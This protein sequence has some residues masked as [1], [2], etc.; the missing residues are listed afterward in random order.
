[1]ELAEE[2]WMK[3]PEMAVTRMEK[4]LKTALVKDAALRSLRET[5][6]ELSGAIDELEAS[7]SQAEKD[8]QIGTARITELG[9]YF[10]YLSALKQGETLTKLVT[11]EK[12]GDN[13]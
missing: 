4:H 6:D 10:H 8:I 1:V 13:A 3:H 9:G 11:H 5:H 12:P 2:E 7:R